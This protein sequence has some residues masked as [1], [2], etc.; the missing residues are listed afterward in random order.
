M[1]VSRISSGKRG[2]LQ[3]IAEILR[4]VRVPTGKTNIKSHCNMSSL[5]SEKYLSF[6]RSSNLIRMDA[7]AGKI[8]YQRTETGREF[9]EQ[10]NDIVLL[11]DPGIYAPS[12][13]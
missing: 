13:V 6:M 2:S 4:K 8:A 12:L 5:Q 10:Y 1:R 7:A 9:L 11:L 3:I